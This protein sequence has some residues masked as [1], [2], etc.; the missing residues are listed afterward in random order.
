MMKKAIMTLAFVSF[1]SAAFAAGTA[2]LGV[3]AGVTGFNPSN[4]VTVGYQNDGNTTPSSYAI[5]SKHNQ[6]DTIYGTTSASTIIGKKP[7]TAGTAL[8]TSDLPSVPANVSDSSLTGW[9]AM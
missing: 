4:N 7:G 9:T 2:A 1:A 3:P 5:A 6:G 8:T